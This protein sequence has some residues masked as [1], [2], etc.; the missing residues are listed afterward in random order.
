[1][2]H[3]H[4][5][6]H[7]TEVQPRDPAKV[8]QILTVTLYLAILTAIEFVLAFTMPRGP[9]LTTLFVLL[10]FVKTYYIVGEFMHLKYEVK[11][12]I[13]AIA[14]PSLFI[15]WLILSQLMEANHVHNSI[16]EIFG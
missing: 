2:G 11:L 4:H 6:G 7:S 12:L 8:K 9:L 15:M 14:L 10:T 1:M 3:A 13:W 16:F 5:S